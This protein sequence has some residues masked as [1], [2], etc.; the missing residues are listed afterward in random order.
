MLDTIFSLI[1]NIIMG[2]ICSCENRDS[3]GKLEMNIK[4]D[5][6]NNNQRKSSSFRIL[7]NIL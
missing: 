1:F 2:N 4:D 6:K 5:R 3:R 7:Y